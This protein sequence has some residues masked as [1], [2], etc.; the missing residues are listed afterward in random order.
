MMKSNRTI[1]VAVSQLSRQKSEPTVI[2]TEAREYSD[3]E[4]VN[5]KDKRDRGPEIRPSYPRNYSLKL[6]TKG[7][8]KNTTSI[9]D[10][11][12]PLILLSLRSSPMGET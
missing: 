1:P 4:K 10:S 12:V 2:I 5:N 7:I 11:D 6:A 9:D 3:I 8:D